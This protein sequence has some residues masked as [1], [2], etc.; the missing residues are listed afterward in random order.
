[1]RS[2]TLPPRRVLRDQHLRMRHRAGQQVALDDGV[3]D[4]LALGLGRGDV[5]ARDDGVER[6]LGAGQ[7]RQAL[8]AAGAGQEAEMDLRQADARASAA[9]TR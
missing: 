8:R 2:R 4:A 3:D 6:V 7:A 9:T 1:M 5:A